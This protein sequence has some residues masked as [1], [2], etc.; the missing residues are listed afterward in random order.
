MR[1]APT[2]PLAI[3]RAI[4]QADC[5]LFVSAPSTSASSSSSSSR[6]RRALNSERAPIWAALA[7]RAPSSPQSSSSSWPS[8]APT[9]DGM[10]PRPTMDGFICV[11]ARVL[12]PQANWRRRRR[13]LRCLQMSS[14][15]GRPTDDSL[16][17]LAMQMKAIIHSR[18]ASSL[19]EA[20]DQGTARS[21][22][23]GC[24]LMVNA[25]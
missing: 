13:R 25:N 9:M 23:V 7:S 4:D 6:A 18:L 16:V 24:R 21:Y 17:C 5:L 11:H 19:L 12:A 3:S 14:L 8:P 2:A 1:C 20:D 10:R 15:A 22:L